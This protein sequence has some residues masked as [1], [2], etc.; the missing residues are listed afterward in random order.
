MELEISQSS[1]MVLRAINN[2]FS[3]IYLYYC[4]HKHL[5]RNTIK[6]QHDWSDHCTNVNLFLYSAS[7]YVCLSRAFYL[8]T[9]FTDYVIK[10]I[11]FPYR[12]FVVIF[13]VSS[14]NFLK[15]WNYFTKFLNLQIL[16]TIRYTYNSFSKDDLKEHN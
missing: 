6:N 5:L 16:F 7:S 9:S 13:A 10:L 3:L 14:P 1:K 8:F 15:I 11:I 4:C 12:Q 2:Q